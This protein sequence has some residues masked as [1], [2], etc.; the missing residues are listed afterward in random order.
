[1]ARLQISPLLSLAR[2]LSLVPSSAAVQCLQTRKLCPPPVM[3]TGP[4]SSQALYFYSTITPPP[5]PRSHA[6]ALPATVSHS[7]GISPFPFRHRSPA[8]AHHLA[9][10]QNPPPPNTRNPSVVILIIETNALWIHSHPL[11]LLPSHSDTLN[12]ILP[13]SQFAS[14]SLAAKCEFRSLQIQTWMPQK[15][16]GGFCWGPCTNSDDS[17]FRFL[18]SFLVL[19]FCSCFFVFLLV[20]SFLPFFYSI[21]SSYSLCLFIASILC[22]G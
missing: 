19:F 8:E 21:Y 7:P 22:C 11:S 17:H 5:P 18:F 6:I 2:A 10:L 15:G 3:T 20:F 4:H 16:A 9:T 13:Q 12:H 14:L 1:M